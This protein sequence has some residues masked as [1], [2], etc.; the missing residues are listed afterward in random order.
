MNPVVRLCHLVD[1]VDLLPNT[2]QYDEGQ[3]FEMQGMLVRVSGKDL[4]LVT[5]SDKAIQ[6]N[7]NLRSIRTH[8]L[9]E[10]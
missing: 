10:S 4:S 6:R 1:I 3:R 5:G 9:L 8:H 2:R 7:F